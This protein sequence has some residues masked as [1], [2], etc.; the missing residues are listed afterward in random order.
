MIHPSDTPPD[1]DFASYVERLTGANAAPG[2]RED[3]LGPQSQ[4]SAAV[5][6]SSS[7]FS[8]S[9]GTPSLKLDVAPMAGMSLLTHIKWV[10][11][12]WIVT[13]A[14]ARF[15]PGTGFL[16]FPA[17]LAYAAWVIFKV[18]RSSSGALVRRL[19][20]L[21]RQAAEEAKKNQQTRQK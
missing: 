14:L 3:L 11:G 7:R 6:P 20:E 15:V 1:G 4:K 19:R 12:L 10:V 17:L 18:N 16:F 21:A 13:Q 2:A 8:A 5:Q 9:S